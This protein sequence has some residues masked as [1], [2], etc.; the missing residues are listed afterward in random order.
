[1]ENHAGPK[2]SE[3]KHQQSA[4]GDNDDEDS[5]LSELNQYPTEVLQAVLGILR[6]RRQLGDEQA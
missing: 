5:M 6:A 2:R 4:K 3:P 1:M